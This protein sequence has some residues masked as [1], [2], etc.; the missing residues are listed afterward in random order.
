MLLTLNKYYSRGQL[1][2][3]DLV[4]ASLLS[5]IMII[6]VFEMSNEL[7]TID[8]QSRNW[9]DLTYQANDA[10]QQLLY[11]Y[12]K[13]EDFIRYNISDVIYFS[14]TASRGV[15]DIERVEYFVNSDYNATREMLGLST[16]EY[17]FE[18]SDMINNTVYYSSGVR[19]TASSSKYLVRRPA[20]LDGRAVEVSL[21]VWSD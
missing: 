1:F 16:G 11:G 17:Y 20:L 18:V 12:S 5:L 21:I 19:P 15:L 3:A 10:S 6:V 8:S 7:L 14:I 2:T 4:I 13:P 9:V